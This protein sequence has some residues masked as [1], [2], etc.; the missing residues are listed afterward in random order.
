MRQAEVASGQA[1]HRAVRDALVELIQAL[2]PGAGMPTER[3]LSERFEVSRGTVRQALDQLE[4]Q[5][6]IHRYQGRGTFVAKPKMDSLLELTSHSDHVRARGMEPGSR[7][8][9]VARLRCDAEVAAM[10]ALSEGDEILQIERVRTADAEPLSVEVLFLDAR[11]FDGLAAM[12][13]E[14]QS[15]YELLRARYGV[16]LSW[17]EETIEAMAAPE[18]EAQLLGIAAAVP[19]LQLSRL[20]FDPIGRPV[21]YVKSLY[22]ADRFRFRTRL[23]PPAAAATVPLPPHTRLRLAT[24]ADAT[25]LAAV[26]VAAWRSGYPGIVDQSVLDAL[27]EA[28]IGD[29]LLAKTTSNGPTTWLLESADGEIIAFSRHGDDPDDGR[30]GHIYS[31]Y[32]APAMSGLGIGKALLDHDLRLLGERGMDTVTLWVFEANQVARNL[33]TSFGFAPDGARRIEPEYGAQEIRMR[34]VPAVGPRLGPP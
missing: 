29:W 4:A 7:L 16:E 17:A 1:K 30:R 9:S 20:S 12:L 3:E 21:E 5:Q 10:L 22:R 34:R 11:R 14:S 8:I 26:F 23:Q 15:L 6:R 2:P 24:A 25:G 33:Y 18:R 27:D 13:G 31:L 32:V 19:V 28:D